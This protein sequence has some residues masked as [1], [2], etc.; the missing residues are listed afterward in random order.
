MKIA[1]CYDGK[2]VSE[3]ALEVALSIR[4]RHPG[5]QVLL[6]G[7]CAEKD[8]LVCE[9]D[10]GNAAKRVGEHCDPVVLVG[11]DVGAA[12]VAFAVAF[13]PHIMVVGTRSNT[14]LMEKLLLGSTSAYVLD[15]AP[16]NVIIAR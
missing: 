10:I 9:K 3:R 4:K 11:D 15:H 8:R 7:V 16:C 1:V 5:S 12:L 14:S 2:P 6:I 13:S